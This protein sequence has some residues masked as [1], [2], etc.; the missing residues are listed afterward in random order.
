MSAQAIVETILYRGTPEPE[1]EPKLRDF[2]AVFLSKDRAA[3]QQY[4]AHVGRYKIPKLKM[5]DAN[6]LEA[7]DLAEEYSQQM[8]SNEDWD[9]VWASFFMFPTADFMM[10][11]RTKGYR[12]FTAGS[13]VAVGDPS[14]LTR[15]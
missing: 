9:D 11:L 6:S 1:T 8:I 12:G 15:A 14:V 2:G 13:D 7:R 5:L 4:G 3:A 10:F